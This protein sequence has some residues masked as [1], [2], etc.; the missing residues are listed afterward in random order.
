MRKSIWR[1]AS[2]GLALVLGTMASAWADTSTGEPSPDTV[3]LLRSALDRPPPKDAAEYAVLQSEFEQLG[4]KVAAARLDAYG[5]WRLLSMAMPPPAT[6]AATLRDVAAAKD[7]EDALHATVD[8]IMKEGAA[9]AFPSGSDAEKAPVPALGP[10]QQGLAHFERL[11]PGLWG[12]FKG[13]EASPAPSVGQADEL[14]MAAEIRNRMTMKADIRWQ[15]DLMP[16]MVL[17]CQANGVPAGEQNGSLCT[18]PLLG[19]TRLPNDSGWVPLTPDEKAYVL[20]RLR[21]LPMTGTPALRALHVYFGELHF[22]VDTDADGHANTQAKAV[23]L[24]ATW[25]AEA[26]TNARIRLN[27]ASCEELGVC[28]RGLRQMLSS[29]AAAMM[30]LTLLVMAGLVIYRMRRG[31]GAGIWPAALKLYAVLFVLAIAVNLADRPAG[32]TRAAPL[33]GTLGFMAKTAL[34]MPWSY[35]VVA[36]MP[37]SGLRPG[38]AAR[39]IADDSPWFWGFA[40]IN[41][42]FLAL[43]AAGGDL[44]TRSAGAIN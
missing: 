26:E 18:V 34:S 15:Y 41:L 7:A 28:A 43:M 19:K 29:S 4:F 17:V 36:G 14:Y 37:S 13:K 2:V 11:A 32:A 16:G 33:S 35:Y 6:E 9:I 27:S 20:E 38:V 1:L 10:T 22:T 21:A 8:R 12:L 42:V 40:T 23:A 3:P 39:S 5:R 24:D 30:V 25:L 44:R 31:A